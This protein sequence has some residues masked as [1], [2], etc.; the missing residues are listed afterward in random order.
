[1][2]TG[3]SFDDGGPVPTVEFEYPPDGRADCH[4][5]SGAALE[6]LRHGLLV[7]IADGRAGGARIRAV[8]LARL[9]GLYETDAAA[10]LAAGVNRSTLSRAVHR[11]KEK[12]K[13]SLC[14]KVS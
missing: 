14:N 7:I 13:G 4:Q 10:A 3:L 11:M 5:T 1:M 2:F 8:A 6:T 9:L 12:I